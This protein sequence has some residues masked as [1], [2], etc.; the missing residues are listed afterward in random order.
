MK[1]SKTN[2]ITDVD[3][4]FMDNNLSDNT[5]GVPNNWAVIKDNVLFIS[6]C[7]KTYAKSSNN[8]NAYITA[9]DL[10]DMSI[11]ENGSIS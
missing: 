5:Y 4:W 7:H 10:S 6:H 9:I 11:M 3:K 8:M 1:A 2:E